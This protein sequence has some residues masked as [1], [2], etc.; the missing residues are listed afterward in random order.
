MWDFVVFIL[1]SVSKKTTHRQTRK[2]RLNLWFKIPLPTPKNSYFLVL[3]YNKIVV[4]DNEPNDNT[5]PQKFSIVSWFVLQY[6][7]QEDNTNHLTKPPKIFIERKS[8]AT[9]KMSRAQCSCK[10]FENLI[11]IVNLS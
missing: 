7:C 10:V 6:D 9:M 2:N 11:S 5:N 4:R 3:C 1:Q 8:C